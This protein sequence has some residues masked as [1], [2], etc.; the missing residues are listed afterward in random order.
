M[1]RN[2]A[3]RS[4]GSLVILLFSLVTSA[5]QPAITE[6]RTVHSTSAHAAVNWSAQWIWANTDTANQWVT[7]RKTVTL[8]SVPSTVITDIAADT[9]YWLFINGSLVIFEGGLKRGPNPNDTYYDEKDIAPYLTTGTNTIAALVWHFG[10]SGFSHKDSG[11]AGFLFQSAIATSDTS[12]K[13]IVHPG[14]TNDTS[15]SQPNSRL[16]ESNVTYDARNAGA[17]TNWQATGYTDSGWANATNKGAAGA[18]PWNAL[19]V[20]PIPLFRYTALEQYTNNSAIPTNGKDATPI[21]MNLPSNLQVTPY[22]KVTA[23]AGAV[24]GI[25]TDHYTDGGDNNVRATYTTTGGTQEFDSLGWMSGTAVQYTIPSSVQIVALGFHE[26]GYDTAFTGSFT[27]NDSFFNTLWTKS[28]RT[29]YLNLRDNFMDC[30]TRERAQWWGDAVNDQLQGFYAF[31][32][33]F[34]QLGN[35]AISELVNWQRGNGTLY[36]PVPSGNWNSELPVQMLA[37]IWSFWNYYLYTGDSSV[38]ATTYSHVKAYMNLW[39]LDSDGLVNHRAGDWDWEDWG[40][41]IDARVLD[42]SWYALALDT[43][44]K[45][46]NLTGNSGDVAAWQ[47]K[48]SSIANNFNRV[49]WNTTNHEYRSPG[50]TGDTDDRA[51]AM[52]VVTGFATT[53]TYANVQNVLR[54]HQNASPYMEFYVLKALYQM[55][56]AS[57]AEARMRSRYASEV[58]DPGYTVWE[59]WS[60]GG[61][62]DNHGWA[63]GP[64]YALSAYAAGV[65]PT[66]PGYAQ[67]TVQPQPGDLTSID[68]TVPTIKGN[69][70]VALR[71]PTATHLTLGVTSPSN[72]TAKISIPLHGMTNV[73][74]TANGTTVYANGAS[75]GNVSGLSFVGSDGVY[76]SFTATSGTWNF[77]ETGSAVTGTAIEAEDSGNTFAGNTKV[78]TCPACSGG[79]R[80]GS[81][82]NGAGNTLTF[83]HVSVP[84]AGSY[85]L[86][87]AYTNGDTVTRSASMSI[88]GGT[89]VTVGNF[90]PTAD[91]NTVNTITTTVA[92]NAGTNTI[93]FGNS[94][95]WAPDFD[96]IMLTAS[97]SPPSVPGG[98]TQCA[99]ENQT[100]SFSGTA[101]VAYGANGQFAYGSFTN[102]TTCSNGVFGDPA[103]G[104]AKTCFVSTGF[105]PPTPGVWTACAAE[106]QTCSFSGT[107]TVAYGASSHYSQLSLTNGTA[108]TNAVFGDPNYG[109]AKACYYQ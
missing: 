3:L 62:T 70:G 23:P 75:T 79:K 81:V 59:L 105:V 25:Q 50:Y 94:S 8:S 72:T 46:A 24:I 31:D 42:N 48:Q 92:L 61:G 60:K 100:C 67:Y 16:A 103:Q 109:V 91:A 65:Q 107:H 69:I 108:C 54:T 87:I 20:R 56:D 73:T 55:G 82:G 17:M 71:I 49:L 84:T 12:W 6:A 58:S 86:T 35:K 57:D 2:S 97:A 10:K 51:N 34:Y 101:T 36:S 68:Q 78:A 80:V 47:S 32:P 38:V 15:G 29:V 76:T 21:V 9:K 28:E 64:M 1:P 63:A 53:A 52:A 66:Q 5:L 104:V 45:L 43:T 22:L 37:S 77:D 39:S 85:T 93:T 88:N 11:A 33:K 13:A 98:W 26:S 14:Y 102:G 18:A 90:T 74:I 19:V 89:A 41:N 95:Y 4:C 44:I 106:N 99:A 83:N 30:P 40:S 96:K 27:S 7:L